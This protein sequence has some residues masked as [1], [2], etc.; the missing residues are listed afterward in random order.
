MKRATIPTRRKFW[1]ALA[2]VLAIYAAKA[3]GLD[4]GLIDQLLNSAAEVVIADPE[5]E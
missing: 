1:L 4:K 2:A 5:A 3:T